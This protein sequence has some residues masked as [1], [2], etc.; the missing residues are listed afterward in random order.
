MVHQR[1]MVNPHRECNPD[2]KRIITKTNKFR[3]YFK[4]LL[5]Y[6][7]KYFQFLFLLYFCQPIPTQQ[8]WKI[9]LSDCENFIYSK[10][11]LNFFF[12]KMQIFFMFIFSFFWLHEFSFKVVDDV[13]T[14]FCIF[15]LFH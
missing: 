9:S 11:K 10:N 15:F 8:H 7:N 1:H 6:L 5:S 3:D 13:T 2:A 4:L 12:G 14:P